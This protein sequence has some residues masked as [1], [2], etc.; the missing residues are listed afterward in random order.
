MQS[1]ISYSTR[2]LAYHPVTGLTLIELMVTLSISAILAVVA[3]PS[4]QSF[5]RSAQL[6]TS[7]NDFLVA[8]SLAR[9]EAIKRGW[10][11]TICKS[12][13]VTDATNNNPTCSSAAT[14]QGGWVLFVN[15]NGAS[16]TDTTTVDNN[17]IILRASAATNSSVA[18]SGGAN[19]GNYVTYLPTGAVKGSGSAGTADNGTFTACL[20]PKSKVI[21]IS[22]TGRSQVSDGACS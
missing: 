17:D 9:S 11:V 1:K 21:D 5:V 8:L 10:P 3:A 12:S 15:L 6:R 14:W 16:D 13:N 20:A 7:T 2:S 19:F 18:V 22:R 4:I